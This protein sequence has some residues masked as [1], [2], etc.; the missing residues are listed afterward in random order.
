MTSLWQEY[1]DFIINKGSVENVLIVSKED[2]SLW[3][4]SNKDDFFLRKY[5]AT[6]TKEDGTEEEQMVNEVTNLLAYI[7]GNF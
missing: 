1:V 7:N 6:I 2:G 4:S 3:A 5:K